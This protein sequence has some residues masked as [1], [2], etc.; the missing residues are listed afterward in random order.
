MKHVLSVKSMYLTHKQFAANMMT[1]LT[2][3]MLAHHGSPSVQPSESTGYHFAPGSGASHCDEYVC[4][5]VCSHNSKTTRPE[6][7]QLFVHVAGGIKGSMYKVMKSFICR[8]CVIPV[9][10]T[11]CASVDIGVS[12]NLELVYKFCYLGDMLSV[13]GDADTA[14]EARIQIG[15]NKFR[16]LVPLLTNNDISLTVRGK[17]L[18]SVL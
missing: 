8:G 10:G 6:L 18:P 7:H 2:T 15:W 14:V 12:A 13:D 11:G 9:I 16:Q 3:T 4:L 1:G 17:F 5:S